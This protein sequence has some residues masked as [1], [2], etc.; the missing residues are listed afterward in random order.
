MNL[1]EVLEF[2]D[3]IKLHRKIDSSPVLLWS[4]GT[5]I[6]LQL[7]HVQVLWCSNLWYHFSSG[8]KVTVDLHIY[9]RD[10]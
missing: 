8:A 9:C 10:T 7:T 1:K 2:K 5:N 6:P 4:S 3:P